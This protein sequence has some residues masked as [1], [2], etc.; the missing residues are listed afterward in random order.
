MWDLASV[1]A[2]VFGL[3]G[4][5]AVVGGI[6]SLYLA[7]RLANAATEKVRIYMLAGSAV[8]FTATA[9]FFLLQVG[10]IN[11][12][13]LGGMLDWQLGQIL[14][15][16][17]LGYSTAIRLGAFLL[18]AFVVLLN[19][20][21]QAGHKSDPRLRAS[22]FLFFLALCS[23]AYSFLLTGH[24]TS[25]GIAA[26]IAIMLHV[27]AV[28][29]WIGTLWPL[30]AFCSLASKDTE[31]LQSVMVGFGK[32][33]MVIVAVLISAGLFLLYSLLESW[34]DIYE[35]PYG[36]GILLK[37]AAVSALLL[38]GAFNKFRLVPKMIDRNGPKL[39]ARSIKI[40]M[41]LAGFIFAITS[42]L[43][44]IVGI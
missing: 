41:A 7:R 14:A 25:L 26:H 4:I 31:A 16:S 30:H 19:I 23:L 34:R 42:Y 18:T 43:T 24:V 10:A 39:L 9:V 32:L 28:F 6:F 13:G 12:R 29:L 35:T 20:T 11:Q 5:A 38:L 22:Q 36:R 2:K 3:F 40:E 33:A 15:Q 8:G 44:I 27:I 21:Y 37:L 17:S 1:A